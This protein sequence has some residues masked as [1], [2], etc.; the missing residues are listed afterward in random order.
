LITEKLHEG[1]YSG[2]SDEDFGGD[3]HEANQSIDHLA[4]QASALAKEE[5]RLRLQLEVEQNRLAIR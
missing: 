1:G 3:D 2:H 5:G 4:A